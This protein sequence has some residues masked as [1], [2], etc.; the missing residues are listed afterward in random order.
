MPTGEE[1]QV[2]EE[3]EVEF[4]LDA[5]SMTFTRAIWVVME[6]SQERGPCYSGKPGVSGLA[7]VECARFSSPCRAGW[8]QPLALTAP[9]LPAVGV[10]CLGGPPHTAL[11]GL[12]K[13]IEAWM[14]ER[15][16]AEDVGAGLG[17]TLALVD[18]SMG[19]PTCLSVTSQQGLSLIHAPP[20]RTPWSLA[21][22][23]QQG[24]TRWG[25]L[26]GKCTQMA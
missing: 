20:S 8:S 19:S 23:P 11:T 14:G 9:G 13:A 15:G 26:P 5:Q 1:A 21:P 10:G 16:G 4:S 12:E 24:R 2:W 3:R 17:R 7:R 6:A 25:H 22:T 18:P